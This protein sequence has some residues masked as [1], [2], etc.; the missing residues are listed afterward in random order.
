[1][2]CMESGRIITWLVGMEYIP[3]RAFHCT[4]IRHFLHQI[5]GD[6]DLGKILERGFELDER[7]AGD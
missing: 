3:K 4:T 5:T 1:M 7:N 2:A 6:E